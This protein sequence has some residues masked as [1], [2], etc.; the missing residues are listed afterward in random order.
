MKQDIKYIYLV[1]DSTI[2]FLKNFPV[3]NLRRSI[4]TLFV[5]LCEKRSKVSF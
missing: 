5:C 2:Q 4:K 3:N 1:L